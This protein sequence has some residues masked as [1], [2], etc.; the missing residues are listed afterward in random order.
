MFQSRFG[1][2]H[3]N[4]D[5]VEVQLNGKYTIK[6]EDKYFDTIDFLIELINEKNSHEY[7]PSCLKIEFFPSCEFEIGKF[8]MDDEKCTIC[9]EDFKI[10][11]VEEEVAHQTD[12]DIYQLPCSHRYHKGCLKNMLGKNQWMK[13]PIC[14]TIF[15]KMIGDQPDGT[16]KHKVDKNMTCPG[17]PQGTIIISYN[18]PAGVRNGKNFPGTSRT[19]Y[20]PN[21]PEGN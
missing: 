8:K 20:L 2:K 10:V 4:D 3:L 19:G 12:E 17:H 13:C 18:M 21:T 11:P 9:L 7:F 6:K 5:E 1:V 14:G 16:M 15:G